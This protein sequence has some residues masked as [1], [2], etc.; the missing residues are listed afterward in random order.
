MSYSNVI[1]TAQQVVSSAGPSTASEAVDTNS[2]V[3]SLDIA[4]T[5]TVSGAQNDQSTLSYAANLLT[6]ALSSSEDRT[7]RIGALQQMI[8]SGT[9]SV[10]AGDVADKVISS[11]V[12]Q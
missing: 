2:A 6:Q 10:P 7:G 9:Y 12:P 8:S 4:K 5:S 1:S 3:K 11:M